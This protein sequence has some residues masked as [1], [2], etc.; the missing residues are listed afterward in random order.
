MK[1]EKLSFRPERRGLFF[2]T[3]SPLKPEKVNELRR[4]VEEPLFDLREQQ[5]SSHR[6]LRFDT[7]YLTRDLS[8]QPSL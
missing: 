6:R 4:V 7:I 1:K 3:L 8:I 5:S 2:H